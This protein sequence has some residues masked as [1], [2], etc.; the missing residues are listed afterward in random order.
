MD[1]ADERYANWLRWA[2]HSAEKG[3]Q[4]LEAVEYKQEVFYF[5]LRPVQP[6]EELLVSLKPERGGG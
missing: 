6:G 2:N 4:N 5:L 3:R 1:G